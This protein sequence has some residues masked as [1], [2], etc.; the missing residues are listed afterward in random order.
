MR[1][2]IAIVCL[3]LASPV[4]AEPPM[5]MGVCTH[6][7]QRKGLLEENLRLI[8]QAGAT[9]IR[10]EVPWAAVERE[11]GVLEVPERVDAY[12][13]AA[14]AEGLEVVLVLDYG[15]QFYEKGM[16]PKEPAS[17]AGFV[18][19]VTFI[20]EHFKG[21]VDTFEV[22]NEW[23]IGIGTATGEKGTP[24]GY[25]NLLIP[26]AAALKEIDPSYTIIAGAVSPYGLGTDFFETLVGLGI[27][28]HCDAVSVH[29]YIYA[30]QPVEKSTAEAC[31]ERLQHF[32]RLLRDANGGE[33]VSLLVTEIGWPTHVGPGGSTRQRAANELARLHLLAATMPNL[34]GIW[35]YDFQDDG[36][37]PTYNEDNFGMVRPDLTPKP[38]FHAYASIAGFLDGAS[39]VD[40]I[41]VADGV[42]ALRFDADGET[43]LALWT[44][45]GN[46]ELI[47]ST[48]TDVAGEPVAIEQVGHPPVTRRW[49]DRDWV[50]QPRNEV[51][52]NLSVVAGPR[53]TLLSVPVT[54]QDL[55]IDVRP[56]RPAE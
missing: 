8:K 13:D 36:W 37:N 56:E 25:M 15:N 11:Q 44:T 2:L 27:A 3:A 18:R 47:L 54:L 39:F 41:Y 31:F 28:D 6:F 22:W 23:D 49:L 16:K 4:A 32:D 10:D 45:A 30:T 24:Q 51:V 29:P 43:R 46:A 55:T 5:T 14:I 33:P 42:Y 40:R 34:D 19:Y 21:R 53:P 20:A 9:S 35:W 7:V 1:Y 17:I 12:V 38:A 52:P 50:K 26:T 48:S